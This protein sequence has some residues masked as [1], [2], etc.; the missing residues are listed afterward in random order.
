MEDCPANK[1][2]VQPPSNTVCLDPHRPVG[3]ATTEAH[4][5]IK[6]QPTPGNNLPVLSNPPRPRE[7]AHVALSFRPNKAN[8]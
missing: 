7:A 8:Q 1:D 2:T 6:A 5:R 3:A 4:G